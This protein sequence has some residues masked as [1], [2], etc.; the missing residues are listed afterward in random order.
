MKYILGIDQGGSKT[1]AAVSDFDGNIV[2]IGISYG[3]NY[4]ASGIECAMGAVKEA[5]DKALKQAEINY[6]KI[7]LLVGGLTGAD[8]A[9]EYTLLTNSIKKTLSIPHVLVVNDCIIAMRAGTDKPYGCVICAGTGLNVAIKSFSGEEYIFGYYVD[10]ADQGGGALS[11]MALK[12]VFQAEAGVEQETMLTEI[13]LRHFKKKTVDDL[14]FNYINH[15]IS[16]QAKVLVPLLFE[17]VDFKDKVACEILKTF[18]KSISRYI[19]AGLNKY[20]MIDA[21]CTGANEYTKFDI[22]LSGGVFKAKSPILYDTVYEYIHER[23]P[24]ANIINTNY[25]PVVGAIILALDKLNLY[26]SDGNIKRNIQVTSEK[27]DLLRFNDG[28]YS[29]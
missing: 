21:T 14:L 19:I 5:S 26:N 11:H 17:A 25:E 2:G 15:N 13:M 9:N 3:A 1:A 10:D 4:S 23:V 29:I 22:V 18:G 28:I 20:N 8:F 7:E 27:F 12:A 6:D 16:T 24:G